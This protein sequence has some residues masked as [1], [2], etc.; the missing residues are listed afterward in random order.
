MRDQ[1]FYRKPFAICITSLIFYDHYPFPVKEQKFTI[2]SI[3]NL[4]EIDCSMYL[5]Y[6]FSFSVKLLQNTIQ[7]Q[8]L[9]TY[10][11]TWIWF[12]FFKFF[13]ETH[14]TTEKLL[15]IS[16]WLELGFW[17]W[18]NRWFINQLAVHIKVK[19]SKSLSKNV[20]LAS[21]FFKSWQQTEVRI[22]WQT[23]G[24]LSWDKQTGN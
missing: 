11:T 10:V 12:F 22:S 15:V 4:R 5:A 20:S 9:T 3:P 2:R 1:N 14:F 21:C 16:D 17:V 18:I 13:R 23:W 24:Q 19:S 7:N 8:S 6:Q